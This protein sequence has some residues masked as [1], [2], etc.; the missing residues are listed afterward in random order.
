[1]ETKIKNNQVLLSLEDFIKMIN[2]LRDLKEEL[3]KCKE[4]NEFLNNQ[5]KQYNEEFASD[6]KQT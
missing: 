5:I 6:N 1:M 4:I 3:S 2:D